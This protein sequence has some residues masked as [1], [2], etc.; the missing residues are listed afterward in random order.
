MTTTVVHVNDPAGFDLY[1]GRAV[2]RAKNPAAHV[3]SP[4]ANP[5]L[6]GDDG[7]LAAIVA[8]DRRLRSDHPEGTWMREHLHELRGLR[9]AC[10]C[11]PVGTVLTADDPLV[12]HCQVL[13]AWADGEGS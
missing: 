13:A 1:C 12:C 5:F 4:W 7:P 11:A 3:A 6:V 8:F 10:W 2:R 9:L